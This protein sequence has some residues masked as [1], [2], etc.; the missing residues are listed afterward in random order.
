[1][2]NVRYLKKLG[3]YTDDT[4]CIGRRYTA[5]RPPNSPPNYYV[6]YYQPMTNRVI[7]IHAQGEYEIYSFNSDSLSIFFRFKKVD[8]LSFNMICYSFNDYISMFK[9]KMKFHGIEEVKVRFSRVTEDDFGNYIFKFKK[10]E[11]SAIFQL[12]FSDFID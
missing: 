5:A 4:V 10:P 7:T 1:M 8:D 6:T 12:Y 9:K 3:L 11:D 2:K